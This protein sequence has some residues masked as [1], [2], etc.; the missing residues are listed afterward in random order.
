MTRGILIAGNESTLYHAIAAEAAKRV[1]HFASALIPSRQI[2][3]LRI[4]TEEKK[5]DSGKTSFDQSVSGAASSKQ[6][7]IALQWNPGSPISARTLV[8]AAENRLDKI[9]EAIL[10]CVPPS[11]RRPAAELT[12]T[13][14]ETLVNDHIKG[15]LYLARELSMVFRERKAGTLALAYYETGT[16]ESKDDPMDTLG[17]SALASFQAFSRSLL[18]AAHDEPYLTMGFSCAGAGAETGFA[19]H[20]FKFLDEENR[21]NNGKLHKYGRLNFLK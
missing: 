1:E 4:P 17:P 6:A 19:S 14:I 15:W 8:I 10:V 20:V 21:R 18:A 5:Q 3:L 11:V 7:A 13:D 12:L 9:N 2:E 16:G